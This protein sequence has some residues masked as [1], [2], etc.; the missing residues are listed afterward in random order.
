M[1]GRVSLKWFSKNIKAVFAEEEEGEEGGKGHPETTA[2][3]EKG[4][5][6]L[7]ACVPWPAHGGPRSRDN[8][9]VEVGGSG[10]GE[11]I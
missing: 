2:G 11:T 4:T 7:I 9:G 8:L 1:C 5:P 10:G 6:V 3:G